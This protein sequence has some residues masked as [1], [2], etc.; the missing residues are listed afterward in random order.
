MSLK[1]RIAKLERAKAQAE[2]A[3]DLAPVDPEFDEYWQAIT[4]REFIHEIVTK[5]ETLLATMKESDALIVQSVCKT[6]VERNGYFHSLPAD[7][8][9]EM[10]GAALEGRYTGPLSLS[11]DVMDAYRDMH[12]FRWGG[13]TCELCGYVVPSAEK[14][15]FRR[16]SHEQRDYSNLRCPLC[17]GLTFDGYQNKTAP[18]VVPSKMEFTFNRSHIRQLDLMWILGK[19]WYPQSKVIS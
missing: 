15:G 5:A 9:F 18:D 4:S 8:Y 13:M 17:N 7:I 6:R 16:I 19:L 3:E 1:S 11:Q 10:L 12:Q 2:E 14:F